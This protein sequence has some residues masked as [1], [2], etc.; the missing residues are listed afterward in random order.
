MTLA[1]SCTN[2]SNDLLNSYLDKSIADICPHGYTNADLNHCA[3][4]V[5]HVMNLAAGSTTCKGMSSGASASHMGVCIRVHSLFA[6][7]PQVDEVTSCTSDTF[8]DGC[9]VFVTARTAV[10][11]A[12]HSMTNVPKKHVGIGMGNTIWH[13]S[14]TQDKVVTTTPELFIYHYSGQTNGLFRGSFPD[15]ATPTRQGCAL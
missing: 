8:G 13:Y 1:C 2:L 4:C 12:G 14:N 15:R 6:E 7:C 5:C 9:F 11:L 3:H 10:N